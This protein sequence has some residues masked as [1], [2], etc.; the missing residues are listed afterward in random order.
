MDITLT[1]AKLKEAIDSLPMI[2]IRLEVSASVFTRL[3]EV[4]RT[5]EESGADPLGLPIK[6]DAMHNDEIKVVYRARS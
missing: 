2:P 5:S 3:M 4:T 1:I 6:V